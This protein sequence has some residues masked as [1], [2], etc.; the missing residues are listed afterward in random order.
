MAFTYQNPILGD[1]STGPKTP[2]GLDRDYGTQ[3]SI[4]SVGGYMEV[5]SLS[6]LNYSSNGATGNIFF[7]GNTIPVKFLVGTVLTSKVFLWPDKVS[8]GRRKLGMLVYVRENDTTYQFRIKDYETLYNAADS[9]GMVVYDGSTYYEV[10]NKS[11][12]TVNAAGQA[13][14]NA[15]TGST[16]EG[17]S[18]V[19]RDN[20]SWIKYHASA[21]E[22]VSI[23][24]VPASSNITSWLGS[25]SIYDAFIVVP[26]DWHGKTI[27]DVQSAFGDTVSS[28]NT[29]VR[30]ELRDSTNNTSTYVDWTHNANN[31]ISTSTFQTPLTLSSGSTLNLV[32]N[33]APDSSAKGYCATFKIQ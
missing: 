31:R 24:A 13:L 33:T 14:L 27:T 9:A 8:S 23:N 17:V 18:G 2:T 10:R 22:Y 11:G 32:F 4:H 26:T 29:I 3:F 5:E 6:D 30:L 16:I 12:T 20:A 19:T 25:N 7:S 28:T 15:W 1:T 21:P